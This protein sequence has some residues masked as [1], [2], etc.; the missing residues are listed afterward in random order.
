MAMHK[1]R[2]TH[3]EPEKI[4]SIM[5][6]SYDDFVR[7]ERRN[8]LAIS[9]AIIF[10]FWSNVS[11]EIDFF[12]LKFTGIDPSFLFGI[13]FLICLYF[14]IAFSIYAYPGY[15]TARQEWKEQTSHLGSIAFEK[16]LFQRLFCKANLSSLRYMTWLHFTYA[17]PIAIGF[18]S[19]LLCIY[20]FIYQGY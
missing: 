4:D 16:S 13:L 20:R 8:L 6:N 15:R 18:L 5:R 11:G 10:A 2:T 1:E 3:G 14:L 7:M 9:S 19:L 17:F 12:G